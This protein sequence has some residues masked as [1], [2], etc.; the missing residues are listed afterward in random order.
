LK[1][2][3][4]A[5]LPSAYLDFRF[6]VLVL[7]LG[8]LPA[9]AHA[10]VSES[11]FRPYEGMPIV[12]V[13]FT[14]NNSTRDFVIEREIGLA[15][16][17]TLSMERVVEGV[18]N[19]VNLGIFGSVDVLPVERENGV[20]LE[21]QFRE[22]PSFIPYLAFRYTEENGFSIG[23][24]LSSVNLFGRAIRVSGRL[25]FG[26]TSE[27]DLM[28]DYPWIT[29]DYHLGMDLAASHLVRDDE[30]R[31]FEETSDE[32]TP[33]IKRYIGKSGRIGAT[34]GYFGMKADRDGITLSP[35]RTDRFFRV[36]AAVGVD[37]RDSWRDPRSGWENEIE[38]LGTFGDGD[39]GT[40]TV[41]VRRFQRVTSKHTL[42]IGILTSLQ[43]GKAGEDVPRYFQYDLGGANSIRGQPFDLGKTL[44]GK[45]QLISTLE[46]QV[47]VLPLRPYH[48]FRWSAAVGLQFALFMDT[49]IAW[50]TSDEFSSHRAK[51]G[52]GAGVRF[53][54]PGSEMVRFDAGLNA[55]GDVYFHFG[56]W[57]KWT[58]QRFRVR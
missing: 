53:L 52:F 39:F 35:D 43:S 58:A 10:L 37:T 36:G 50:S 2:R 48:F 33:W 14:G 20:S 30:V 44:C 16:G 24:A 46:Y 19:L 38:L 22:M 51:T 45:N 15:V 21:Y 4:G 40:A 1:R 11:V 17:D 7:L 18:R 41:D 25:L 28:V 27:F 57:F 9:T 6:G 26:G 29:G 34:A 47:S 49:G 56:G 12:G 3:L 31:G 32:V 5:F 8:L 55:S 23:P 13:T 54:V 42:F